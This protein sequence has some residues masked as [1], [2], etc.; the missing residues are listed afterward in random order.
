VFGKFWRDVYDRSPELAD[1]EEVL[2]AED[3]GHT[4]GWVHFRRS[5]YCIKFRGFTV[6]P[7]FRGQGVA[8]LLLAGLTDIATRH[9]HALIASGEKP[10][11]IRLMYLK[12]LV[13]LDAE[14]PGERFAFGR[15]LKRLGFTAYVFNKIELD[16]EEVAAEQAYAKLQPGMAK[17]LKVFKRLVVDG[18]VELKDEAKAELLRLTPEQ[19]AVV[20]QGLNVKLGNLDRSGRISYRY[21][22]CP[23]CAHM[24]SSEQDSA[25]CRRCFIYV[26]CM[27]PFREKGR[28]K[29]D[30]EVSGAYFREMRRFLLENKATE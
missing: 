22:L 23:I 9:H 1:G 15:F 2:I 27:E 30:Y 12:S 18:G 24:G 16:E 13:Y 3:G 29:E 7:D 26:T 17:S 10:N 11:D 14:E 28:F 19:L 4:A 6:H 25:A 8:K 20:M 5:T 21:D